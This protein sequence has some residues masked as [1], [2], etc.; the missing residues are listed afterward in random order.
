VSSV[1]FSPDNTVLAVG[2]RDGTCRLID[3]QGRDRPHVHRKRNAA[4]DCIRFSKNGKSA[5]VVWA[6]R[7]HRRIEFLDLATHESSTIKTNDL[8]VSA[9]DDV[10]SKSA[11]PIWRFVKSDGSV[12]SWDGENFDQVDGVRVQ[13][14][15][16]RQIRISE[17]P[18]NQILSAD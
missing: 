16:L 1:C 18:G 17:I 13:E 3:L 5:A 12:F 10:A 8:I 6:D 9:M 11:P 2:T 15:N 14:D 4:V 7:T